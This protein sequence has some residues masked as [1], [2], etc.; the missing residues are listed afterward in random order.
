MANVKA[1]QY[2][3][4]TRPHQA[5]CF[6]RKHITMLKYVVLNQLFMGTLICKRISGVRQLI[7]ESHS[8][9][10]NYWT[11][12]LVASLTNKPK[13]TVFDELGTRLLKITYGY[14]VSQILP[15]NSP[16]ASFSCLAQQLL[17]KMSVSLDCKI[18]ILPSTATCSLW[19]HAKCWRCRVVGAP[20]LRAARGESH[21]DSAIWTHHTTRWNQQ[22]AARAG[23]WFL[24][25][26]VVLATI[27]H[28][29]LYISQ[30]FHISERQ[31][32]KHMVI[33]CWIPAAPVHVSTLMTWK[34][35]T[36][37]TQQFRFVCQYNRWPFLSMRTGWNVKYNTAL[38]KISADLLRRFKQ[39]SK[40]KPIW[41][42]NTAFV[43]STNLYFNFMIIQIQYP[44]SK[45]FSLIFV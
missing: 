45:Y 8:Q 34:F 6:N 15:A 12:G 40:E 2:P 11:I 29:I 9:L 24:L 27:S 42:S 39:Q 13:A 28:V 14:C 30:S 26:S 31:C 4:Y 25:G 22:R 19:L 5:A 20:E 23:C 43:P 1:K 36:L 33:F 21:W 32:L 16:I 3:P 37:I 18:F 41:I 10:V 35:D 17:R 7:I 44:L 38:R